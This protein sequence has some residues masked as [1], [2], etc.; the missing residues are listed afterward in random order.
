[1]ASRITYLTNYVQEVKS[2]FEK[3]VTKFDKE[4]EVWFEFKDQPL[5]W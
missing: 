2:H 5:K 3:Y 1:M 4:N